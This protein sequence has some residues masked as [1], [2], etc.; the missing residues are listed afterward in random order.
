MRIEDYGGSV[1][2]T[3]DPKVAFLL[4]A[5]DNITF[6]GSYSTSFRAP[7]VYQQFGQQTALNQVVDPSR[8]GA[9]SFAG[10]RTFGNTDLSPEESTAINVGTTWKPFDGFR[11]DLDA[12]SFDFTDVIIAENFQAVVN[13]DPL[14]TDRI[15]RNAGGSIVQVN[16]NF[17]NASSVETS[18]LDFGVS[19]EAD[20][21][22]ATL[23]PFFQGTKVF[24]YDLEDPQ[25]GNVDGAGNRNFTNFG[26]SVP[27]LRF[28]TG[29]NLIA[30]N[31]RLDVFGRYIDDYDDDQ[32]GNSE[33]DSHFTIDGRYTLN[34]GNMIDALSSGT[35]I[36]VGVINATNED[37]P[38]VF[39]N[40]GFDSKVHDPRGRMFY[41]G[42]D[43]GF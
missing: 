14:S 4:R 29:F 35:S 5:D 33:I 39:T 6:R 21:G 40:G 28:N 12:Y 3:L 23:V 20:I 18:G 31:H 25:A 17:V 1:G 7:T 22:F 19:Y 36:S 10:V 24:S 37:P 11:I 34:V 8:S 26:T 27:K 2:S 9:T 41:A 15:I 32:N 43:I 38:Q 13:Q 30:D 42:I 16:T